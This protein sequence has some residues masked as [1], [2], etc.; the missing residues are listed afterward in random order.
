LAETTEHG[1]GGSGFA[2]SKNGETSNSNQRFDADGD[3]RRGAHKGALHFEIAA[4]YT[5]PASTRDA[6]NFVT[7]L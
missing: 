1:H 3:E 7:N 4:S 5:R 2:S 6:F